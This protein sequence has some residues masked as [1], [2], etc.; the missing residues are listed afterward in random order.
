MPNFV[1][2]T[3][4]LVLLPILIIFLMTGLTAKDQ[5]DVSWRNIDGNSLNLT[6]NLS[7]DLKFEIEVK[8]TI[9]GTFINTLIMKLGSNDTPLN[10]S[11]HFIISNEKAVKNFTIGTY[12]VCKELNSF[13]KPY[14]GVFGY[15][16]IE[17]LG[18]FPLFT[19]SGQI[20]IEQVTE[21]KLSGFLDVMMSNSKGELVQLKGNFR[22][23]R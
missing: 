23:S 14:D 8:E 1:V 16:N 5:L 9:N 19:R 12:Q 11:L 17:S 18:E 15:A 2:R 21:N 6:K 10:H 13:M 3:F 4:K 7:K 22:A 20:K